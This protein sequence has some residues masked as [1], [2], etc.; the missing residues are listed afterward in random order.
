MKQIFFSLLAVAAVQVQVQGQVAFDHGVA[1]GDALSDR[2]I[3]WTRVTP[4]AGQDTLNVSWTLSEDT[5]FSEAAASGSFV[6]SADRDYTVKVDVTGL[7]ADTWYYYQ[8]EAEGVLSP[9]GRTRTL[10]T[11]MEDVSGYRFALASCANWEGGYF[12]AYRSIAERNDLQAVFFLGDYMYEYG[13]SYYG[14]SYDG[15]LHFPTTE[16]TTLDAYRARHANYKT[17]PDLQAAHQQYP[18]YMAWDDHE[19]VNNSWS[20]GAENHDPETEGDYHERLAAA[21][22]AYYEWNPVRDI[23]LSDVAN[24][25][26]AWR[27]IEVGGLAKFYFLET[28]LNARSEQVEVP[29]VGLL[30]ANPAAYLSDPANLM[31]VYTANQAAMN[32][33][34]TML[35][36]DQKAWLQQELATSNATWNVIV[37]QTVMAGLPIV[38]LTAGNPALGGASIADIFAAQ[39]GG[40]DIGATI[41]LSYDNW[42]GY[43]ADKFTLYGM[44]EALG[45]SNP[46]VVT[47]DIHSAWG[48]TLINDF[49]TFETI[50]VEFVTTQIAGDVRSFGVPDDSVKT[51]IPYVN[52]FRQMVSGY[53]VLDIDPTRTQA[54]YVNVRSTLGAPPVWFN[55]TSGF[56]GLENR[57]TF[58]VELD[59][60]LVSYADSFRPI[61]AAQFGL[62]T[63]PRT[64]VGALA[65]LPALE[66]PA[67]VVTPGAYRTGCLMPEACNYDATATAMEWMV[68]EFESC[69]G[70]KYAEACNYDPAALYDAGE[71]DFL[72][73]DLNADGYVTASDLLTFLTQFSA[74]CGE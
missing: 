23:D 58:E 46:V 47:G 37:N 67:S 69:K 71:C 44:M 30:Y 3:I 5:L 59:T 15:R 61:V 22:Q 29:N 18:W 33:E 14:N 41:A 65:P 70:C 74:V 11:Q 36:N 62:D 64:L 19:T 25:V 56:T 24:S 40:L 20:D 49:E 63:L 8:F 31:G 35:G 55:P 43:L 26:P 21:L 27:S 9:I 39:T 53:T 12:N 51:L 68:C 38:D 32:P 4:E 48:N 2:T 45:V 7:E 34:R 1:S 13:S 57:A 54:D 60:S 72:A 66:N 6:T 52:H 28:R 50:G 10:P 16:V 17:D 42:D 73:G